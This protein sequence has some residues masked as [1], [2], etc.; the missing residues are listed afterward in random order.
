VNRHL[1]WVGVAALLVAM[2]APAVDAAPRGTR[3]LDEVFDELTLTPDLQ[4]GRAVNSRGEWE[5]LLLNVIEP[6]G[7]EAPWRGA[8][9][10]VHGGYFKRGDRYDYEDI[11]RSYARAGYV[12][13][14]IDYRL[15]PEL[16]EGLTLELLLGRIDEYLDTITDAQHDAQA[17]IRWVRLHA[18]EYRIDPERI[19]VAG[20]SAGGLTANAVAFNDDDPGTS[21]SPGPSSKVAAAVSSAGAGLPVKHL[22]IN[23]GDAPIVYIH[24]LMDTV[25]PYIGAA[26]PCAVTLAFLNVCEQVLDPDQDH[27]S[28]GQANALEFLYRWMINKPDFRPLP[29]KLTLVP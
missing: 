1:R 4:Y 20:H 23:T 9:V 25:V 28:F 14:S 12:V 10:W 19:A 13:F 8:V 26:L 5:D 17:A 21:G 7:D 29:T 11:W 24:G 16:P 22:H 6:A 2:G 18:A 15:R 3:Y 27:G